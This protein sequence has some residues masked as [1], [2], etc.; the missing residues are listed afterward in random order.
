MWAERGISWLFFN[1]VPINIDAFV[2]PLHELEESLLVK[3]SVC[4]AALASSFIHS[5]IYYSLP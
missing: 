3:V 5:F 4:M 1:I 2:P